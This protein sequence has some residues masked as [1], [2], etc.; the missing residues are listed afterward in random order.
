MRFSEVTMIAS[1]VLMLHL[2]A[3]PAPV[4]AGGYLYRTTLV[5]AAPGKLLD[6]IE[7]WREGGITD[8]AYLNRAGEI[9]T[10]V[11]DRLGDDLPPALQ[12]SDAV[13]AFYGLV[14]EVLA[15]SDVS[16]R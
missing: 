7:D 14:N 5:Q 3:G 10:S 6:V 9:E 1:L 8:D 13:K 15:H 11:L 2:A 4:P 12:Y 16:A